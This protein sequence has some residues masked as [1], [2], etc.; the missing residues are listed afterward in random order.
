LGAGVSPAYGENTK[1]VDDS[2][3]EAILRQNQTIKQANE[4]ATLIDDCPSDPSIKGVKGVVRNCVAG[5][6]ASAVTAIGNKTIINRSVSR[7][8]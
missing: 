6:D 2:I 3:A 7:E 1:V 5:K 8:K 4:L